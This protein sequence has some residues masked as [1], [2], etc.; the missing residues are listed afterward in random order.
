MPPQEDDELVFTG[1]VYN[2]EPEDDFFKLTPE[3][4]KGMQLTGLPIRVEHHETDSGEVVDSWVSD[5]GKAYVK[6]RFSDNPRGWGLA[7]LVRDGKVCELSLKHAEFG[8]GTKE[9]MEVSVVERG[10]RPRTFIHRGKPVKYICASL[11]FKDAPTMAATEQAAAP[12][13]YERN[14]DGTFAPVNIAP[15]PTQQVAATAVAAAPAAPA[16][17]VGEKRPAEAAPEAPVAD[18]SA[19]QQQLDPRRAKVAKLAQVAEKILPMIPDQEL[20]M[21]LVGSISDIIEAATE[22]EKEIHSLKKDR[23]VGA[24]PPT[25]LLRAFCEE[26]IGGVTPCRCSRRRRRRLSRTTRRSPRRL[27]TAS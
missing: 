18:A 1:C 11:R 22:Q 8:D 13:Y 4:L 5:D 25:P 27:S 15:A 2:D 7:K 3:D 14:P 26:L 21:S 23:Q 24:L 17:V 6:W 9:A 20:S 10:A 16:A 19:Q 12:R